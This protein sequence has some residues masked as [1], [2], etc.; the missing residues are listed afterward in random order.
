[1]LDLLIGGLL[2]GGMYVLMAMGLSLVFGV[3]KIPNFAHGEFYMIGAYLAFYSIA[4]WSL[5]IPLVFIVAAVGGFIIGGII[6]KTVFYPLRKR[7]KKDWVLNS[8]LVTAGIS[9]ILINQAQ[10]TLGVEYK[11]VKEILAGALKIGTMS[12]SYD[13]I[14]G[15]FIAMTTLAFFW[16]FLKRTKSGNAIWAVSE[17]ETGALLMG[18]D[19]NKIQT[20]TF[21]LSCMLASIAGAALLSIIPAYPTMGVQPLMKSW[22]VVILVGLGNIEATIIGGFAVGLI[23]T[24]A[25]YNFGASWQDV[26]SLTLIIMVLILKPS[27]LFGKRQKV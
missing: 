17:D 25:T 14:I 10:A 16:L 18:I 20:L 11:G 15:F 5:P 22:L 6:E 13:R 19:L 12:L 7:S 26:I 9:F 24:Y 21:S 3:M 8:F 4:V 2:R 1:M 23:E 27:G